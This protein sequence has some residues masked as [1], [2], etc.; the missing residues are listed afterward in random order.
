VIFCNALAAS[1]LEYTYQVMAKDIGIVQEYESI[2]NTFNSCT[3]T[4]KLLKYFN[5]NGE[6][7]GTPFDTLSILG[8]EE[9]TVKKQ[10]VEVFPN[11]V[12]VG[13]VLRFT[14]TENSEIRIFNLLGH[15]VGFYQGNEVPIAPAMFQS[16][17]YF[18]QL[19]ANDKSSARGKFLVE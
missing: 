10:A 8:F 1:G 2:P 19:T 12:K 15:Q 7:W 3:E 11:P 13:D 14:Q 17:I 4:K 9:Q 16:G 5:H 18:W 6:T